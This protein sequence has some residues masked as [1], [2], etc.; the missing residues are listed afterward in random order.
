[1]AANFKLHYWGPGPHTPVGRLDVV[2]EYFL[3][4]EVLLQRNA[5]GHYGCELHLVHC[6][7]AGVGREI[8]FQ[9]L[10]GR[11]SDAGR[12]PG[13]CRCIKNGFDKLVV[14]HG[15]DRR[16]K[17]LNGKPQSICRQP[18]RDAVGIG[19]SPDR[20]VEGWVEGCTWVRGLKLFTLVVNTDQVNN[21]AAEG[22]PLGRAPVGR[23]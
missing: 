15:I 20:G 16:A 19:M 5:A 18:L 3:I 12:E 1:M 22:E 14:G 9:D 23:S 4:R 13:Q 8:L 2:G 21:D 17:S 7:A 11:P 6:A 10:F